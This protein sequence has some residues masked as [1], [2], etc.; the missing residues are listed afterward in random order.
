MKKRVLVCLGVLLTC[1]LTV[2]ARTRTAREGLR[3][4]Y[5][6][7]MAVEPAPEDVSPF[8][9]AQ[10]IGDP[11]KR[12]FYLFSTSIGKYTISKSGW[13]EVYVG[14]RKRYFQ[15]RM[16]AHGHIER[17][18]FFEYRGELLLLYEAGSSAFLM[19]LNESTRR[20]KSTTAIDEA[21]E[22]PLLK[23]QSLVFTDG[24]IVSLD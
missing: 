6:A 24:T 17:L 7:A 4:L 13:A 1:A 19:R 11:Q 18:Y 15:L 9:A 8:L 2:S 14:N 16:G 10:R 22:P 5:P 23:D 20:I 21:F 3:K 12:A